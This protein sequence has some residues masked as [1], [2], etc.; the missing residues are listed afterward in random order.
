[1]NALRV[2]WAVKHYVGAALLVPHWPSRRMIA[3]LEAENAKLRQMHHEVD[4][5]LALAS[6]ACGRVAQSAERLRKTL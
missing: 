5:V 1:M 6:G 4:A 3:R 2:A